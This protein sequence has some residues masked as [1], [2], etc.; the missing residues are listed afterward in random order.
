MG[1]PG[2]DGRGAAGTHPPG[3]GLRREHGDLSAAGAGPALPGPGRYPGRA[4]GGLVRLERGQVLETQQLLQL[5]SA[6]QG[7]YR[8]GYLHSVFLSI[9]TEC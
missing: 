7:I 6:P 4:E 9:R 1:Y 5:V 2:H 3:R 8:L